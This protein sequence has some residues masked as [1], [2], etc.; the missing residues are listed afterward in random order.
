MDAY[1]GVTKRLMRNSIILNSPRFLE[2][3]TASQMHLPQGKDVLAISSN[4]TEITPLTGNGGDWRTP[5]LDYIDRGILPADKWESRRLK[6]KSSNYASIDGRL[7]RWTTNKLLLTCV[8][9]E[10]AELVM[11]ETHEG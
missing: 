1:L 2:K 6:A 3:K 11:I 4:T 5:F 7:H 10:D 9:K 8:G